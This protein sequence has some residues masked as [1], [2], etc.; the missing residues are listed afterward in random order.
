MKSIN[1]FHKEAQLAHLKQTARQTLRNLCGGM[2]VHECDLK[3][4]QHGNTSGATAFRW[5]LWSRR[6]RGHSCDIAMC[7]SDTLFAL[8]QVNCDHHL[9]T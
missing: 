8:F 3:R 4:V 5:T 9:T 1:G 2:N 6:A 7:D